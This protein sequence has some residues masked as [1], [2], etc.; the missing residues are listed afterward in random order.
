[1]AKKRKQPPKIGDIKLTDHQ[2][3]VI[4]QGIDSEFFQ[5]IRDVI[6]P[7]R[8][9]QIALTLL[10]GGQNAEDLFFYKGM[11]HL[12]TWFPDFISGEAEKVDTAQYENDDDEGT[13][14]AVDDHSV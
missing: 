5:I 7:Q 1:M 9:T 11:T 8:V 3:E 4:A 14:D 12:T 13:I 2:R 6:I 10:H